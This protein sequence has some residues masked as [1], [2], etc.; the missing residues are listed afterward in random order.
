MKGLVISD[1]HLFA[2][3]SRAASLVK[4]ISEAVARAQVI[5]LNGDIFDVQWTQQPTIERT[6]R[7]AIGWL[8]GF[9]ILVK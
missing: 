6:V 8:D 5:V 9:W 3:R 1:L 7:D 4:P 2:H